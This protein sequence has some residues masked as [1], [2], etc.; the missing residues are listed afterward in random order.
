M[1]ML[2][3]PES[4]V[5]TNHPIR[6]IKKMADDTLNKLGVLLHVDRERPIWRARFRVRQGSTAPEWTLHSSRAVRSCLEPAPRRCS[7]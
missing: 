7:R 5:P 6:R 2:M 4:R 1:L 3:S